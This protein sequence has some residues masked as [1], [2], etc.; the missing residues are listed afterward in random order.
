MAQMT[1]MSI[2]CERVDLNHRLPAY[3]AGKLPLLYS[4]ILAH[5]T[6]NFCATNNILSS[7]SPSKTTIII[8][9]LMAVPVGILVGTNL[10]GNY[11]EPSVDE[12]N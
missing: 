11:T 1:S 4:A 7:I 2:S 10:I 6:P 9:F 5:I 12:V 8:K 3:E